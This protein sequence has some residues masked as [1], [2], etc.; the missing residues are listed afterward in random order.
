MD[1]LYHFKDLFESIPGY[2]KI[3]L[4][5][6]SIQNDRDLLGEIGFSGPDINRLNLDFK[7]KFLEH[8]EEYLGFVKN[9]GESIIE[10][11]LNK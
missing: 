2:R 9:E 1:N 5:K 10:R 6:F 7:N 3:V 8:H 4:L 11:F